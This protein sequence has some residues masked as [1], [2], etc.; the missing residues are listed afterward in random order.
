M[1][2][3]VKSRP[4][5]KHEHHQSSLRGHELRWRCQGICRRGAHRHPHDMLQDD[6]AQPKTA[7]EFRQLTQE[8]PFKHRSVVGHVPGQGV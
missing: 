8:G 2:M 3:Y 1:K 4:R 7:E 6:T 5:T